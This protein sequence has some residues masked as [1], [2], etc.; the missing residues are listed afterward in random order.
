MDQSHEKVSN[1]F[2]F[3]PATDIT[4]ETHSATRQ[5]FANLAHWVIDNVPPSDA[6]KTCLSRLREAMMWANGA[7]ACHSN[8]SA[9][10]ELEQPK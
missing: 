8:D 4:A 5:N 7:I 9:L 3:H 1:D 2:G 10:V 6:R